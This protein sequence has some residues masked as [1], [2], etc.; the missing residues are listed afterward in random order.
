MLYF[1]ENS[2]SLCRDSP[3]SI[4]DPLLCSFRR[5]SAAWDTRGQG[6]VWKTR[7]ENWEWRRI[8]PKFFY[9]FDFPSF[10]NLLEGN[11]K[12]KEKRVYGPHTLTKAMDV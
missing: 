11:Y 5:H 3:Q 8:F 2:R 10:A 7:I 6:L 1:Y 12:L 4:S 9:S